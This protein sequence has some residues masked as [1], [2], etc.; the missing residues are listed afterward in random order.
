MKILMSPPCLNIVQYSVFPQNKE[1]SILYSRTTE[2]SVNR[3]CRVEYIKTF[4]LNHSVNSIDFLVSADIMSCIN[5]TYEITHTTIA[6]LYIHS[7]FSI[8][9]FH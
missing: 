6:H 1:N 8:T 3:L 5:F 9:R 7:C 4:F 2:R